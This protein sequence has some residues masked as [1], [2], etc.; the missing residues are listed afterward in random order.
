MKEKFN[1]YIVNTCDQSK[2][3]IEVNA[4]TS[5]S[6]S[7]II[8]LALRSHYGRGVFLN[9]DRGLT[10]NG[11]RYFGQLF[12]RPHGNSRRTVSDSISGRVYVDVY[13][14]DAQ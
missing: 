14:V 1:V 9:V 2:Q 8:T 7:D 4:P 12:K 10:A 13:Q 6:D 5:A 3:I 11:T